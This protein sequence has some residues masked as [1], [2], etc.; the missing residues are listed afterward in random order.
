MSFRQTQVKDL[1]TK[2][3]LP[4]NVTEATLIKI[5]S[6]EPTVIGAFAA[7]QQ[8]EAVCLA[9]VNVDGLAIQ[10]I[11]SPLYSVALAAVTN[12][13]LALKH[14]SIGVF[15]NLEIRAIEEAAVSNDYRAL[16]FCTTINDALIN[17]AF[18]MWIYES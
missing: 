15:T 12:N 11:S 6:V 18:T 14:I 1:F 3:I 13:G 16:E 2:Y 9:A 7:S 17:M 8:T 4:H 10:Y 5:A